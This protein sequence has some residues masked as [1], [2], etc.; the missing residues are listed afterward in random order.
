[1]AGSSLVIKAA[2]AP[3]EFTSTV[4]G[5]GDIPR[6]QPR[7]LSNVFNDTVSLRYCLN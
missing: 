6:I 2:V 3:G 7:I 5:L 4:M 1:M